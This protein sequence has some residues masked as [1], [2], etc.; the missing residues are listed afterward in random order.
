[1][2]LPAEV[3]LVC[4]ILGRAKPPGLPAGPPGDRHSLR[5]VV[6]FPREVGLRL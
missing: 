4:G 3:V 2:C 6:S 1:M 5:Q